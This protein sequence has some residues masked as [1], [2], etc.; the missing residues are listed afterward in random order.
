MLSAGLLHHNNCNGCVRDRTNGCKNPHSCTSTVEDI[1][2]K[3]NQKYN[4][5]SPT[6]TDNLTLTHHCVKKNA[7]ANIARGDEITFHPSIMT[8]TSLSDCF[9]IFA[10]LLQDPSPALCPLQ[11]AQPSLPLIIY[12]DSLCLHNDQQNMTSGAG[13]WV[14]ENHPLNCGCTPI[15]SFFICSDDHHRLKIH[16]TIP[17]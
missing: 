6:N 14:A 17:H 12:T 1:L 5:A 4:P 15:S 3:I 9:R 11:N 10:S 7:W 16:D 2:L 8:R 13:I